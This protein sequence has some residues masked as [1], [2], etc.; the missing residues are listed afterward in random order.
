[1]STTQMYKNWRLESDENQILW[2]YFD[3]KHASV[4]TI[5]REVMDEFSTILDLLANDSQ[6]KGVIITSGKRT[7][8]IA[9]ADI[10]QFTQ[11]KDIEDATSV[12]TKGQHIFDKLE[13]LK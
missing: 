4:N 10:S 8:F 3:K 11:F 12:L 1:M 6:H 7:G 5:D 9:G 2:L 13:S